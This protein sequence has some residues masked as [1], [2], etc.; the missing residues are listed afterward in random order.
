MDGVITIV[1]GFFVLNM[2]FRFFKK[3]AKPAK[4][5]QEQT[6]AQ[7]EAEKPKPK[8]AVRRDDF[9]F[10]SLKKAAS[11]RPSLRRAAIRMPS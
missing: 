1:I 2:I 11:E 6:Q 4:Q 10:P 3:M 5:N 9:R 8:P 7:A